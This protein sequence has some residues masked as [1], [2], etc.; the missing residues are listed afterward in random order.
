[1]GMIAAVIGLWTQTTAAYRHAAAITPCTKR[2]TR[3]LLTPSPSTR[4]L[5]KPSPLHVHGMLRCVVS[6]GACVTGRLHIAMSCRPPHKTTGGM[7]T[8][9]TQGCA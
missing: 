8:G 6:Q 4:V 5:V 3:V 1:M 7:Y 9:A 2:S